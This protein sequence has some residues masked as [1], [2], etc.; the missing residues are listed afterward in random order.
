M[1]MSALGSVEP[2]K[3]IT[4]PAIAAHNRYS[5]RVALD[6][7]GALD[8]AAVVL[9]AILPAKI[10]S[11][12]GG[13]E[14]QW[15]VVCQSALVTAFL[16]FACMRAWNMYDTTRMHDLPVEPVKL[17][18][19]LVMATVAALGLGV[20]FNVVEIHLW[21]WY[22]AWISASFTC[23]LGARIMC[24]AV[25][26]RMTAEGRFDTR[27][28]VFGAGEIARRVQDHL[29]SQKTGIH[30]VGVYDDRPRDRLD[31]DGLDIKGRL[32]DLI[33]AGR[34][35]SIDQIVIALPQSA[36]R[37]MSMIAAKLEQLPVSL[38]LVTHI[39]SDLIDVGPAHKVSSIG[40]VGLLDVK[41][42]PLNDWAP[43][44]K[45]TEDVV[46]GS[47][48]LIAALPLMAL[49]AM[50][51]MLESPGPAIF[52]QR[53]RGLNLVD[54]D[55]YKF[56]TMRVMENGTEID[57]AL[58]NDPRV[59][60]VGSLLRRTS[61]DELPQLFNVLRGDMA[62]V[63]PRPHA[64]AHDMKWSEMMATYGV[65]HQVKPGITGLAQVE[66]CRGRIEGQDDLAAR[67][68]QDVSYIRNWSLG[69]DLK[70]LSRTIGAALSGKNAH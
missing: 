4:A 70:I 54:I 13:L 5:R 69:L 29:K 33:E 39:S 62:L 40:S 57:Q 22:A 67:V 48:L 2:F 63:G 16:L 20:P 46:V 17:F 34:N 26:A 14:V 21:I 52:K 18:G 30:Y 25:L 66:G 10:Y 19:A 3:G 59:T 7:V 41:T 6:I 56:R 58:E 51:V 55:V 49:I 1:S 38:H 24:R 44:V 36:D 28:A 61:L 35:G 45:R 23:I 37:R 12:A 53:R 27:I 11:S 68:S 65:R 50:A 31:A 60:R 42:K 47:L 15:M 43:F 9:G 32:E 64:I 8:V